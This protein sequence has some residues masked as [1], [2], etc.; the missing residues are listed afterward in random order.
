MSK[1]LTYKGQIPIGL[2]ERIKLSTLNGKTGYKI[3]KF[4][5]LSSAPGAGDVEYIA[6]IYKTDASTNIN[7]TPDFSNGSLLA[8]IYYQDHQSTAYPSSTDIIFDGVVF[9]Q[10][11]HINVSD[12]G[13]GTVPC[14][15]YIELEAMSLT[16]IQATQLTLKALR[17]VASR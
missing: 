17:N 11:I 5:I 15:Y 13:G 14:N 12:A 10:D 8:V 7:T 1:K 2:Q 4:Q 9:N 6:Q 16:D 3:T